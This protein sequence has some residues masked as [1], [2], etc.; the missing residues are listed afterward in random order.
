MW[1]KN[2]EA[3]ARELTELVKCLSYKL[4]DPNLIPSKEL[5]MVVCAYGPIAGEAE[6][7]DRW[8]SVASQPSQIRKPQVPVRDLLKSR[9]TATKGQHLRLTCSSV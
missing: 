3:G 6:M 2:V 9:W 8:G 4:E 1:L 5:S 7:E